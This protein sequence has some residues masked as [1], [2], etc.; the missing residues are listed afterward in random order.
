[1]ALLAEQE[2]SEDA[3]QESTS[4]P[5]LAELGRELEAE[6][7]AE[8]GSVDSAGASPAASAGLGCQKL[9][10]GCQEEYCKSYGVLHTP[11]CSSALSALQA[12]RSSALPAQPHLWMGRQ[13]F[14]LLMPP[15]CSASTSALMVQRWRGCC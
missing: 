1:M 10:C 13:S 3:A 15:R 9:S 4:I 11:C 14:D 12:V 2:I 7:D 8:V 6:K 5:A